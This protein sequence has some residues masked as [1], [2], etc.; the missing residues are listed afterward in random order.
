MDDVVKLKLRVWWDKAHNLLGHENRDVR[1]IAGFTIF[2]IRD[3]L[4]EEE[5]A[6]LEEDR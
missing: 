5:I 3:M 4:T 1:D 2:V 6:K